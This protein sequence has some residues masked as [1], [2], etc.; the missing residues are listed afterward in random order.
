MTS[1]LL[2]VGEKGRK[3]AETLAP[4]AFHGANVP[5]PVLTVPGDDDLRKHALAFRPSLV[6]DEGD[7]FDVRLLWTRWGTLLT[8]M[9]LAAYTAPN[10]F[11]EG[12]AIVNQEL[13]PP[14]AFYPDMPGEVIL[15]HQVSPET[16]DLTLACDR[17]AFAG[18][19]AGRPLCR[20]PGR[21][22]HPARCDP[23]RHARRDTLPPQP[24][25]PGRGC[26]PV[27]CRGG[28]HRHQRDHPRPVGRG[29]PRRR[30]LPRRLLQ[31]VPPR[32]GGLAPLHRC[33]DAAQGARH[34]RGGAHPDHLRG[35]QQRGPWT[36]SPVVL[37]P[38]PCS[39]FPTHMEPVYIE[40]LALQ[41]PE[42]GTDE[43]V[44]RLGRIA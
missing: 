11:S 7:P 2:F 4:Q 14:M 29:R 16:G 34:H 31:G 5:T 35:G 19:G 3:A 30:Q 36:A 28:R 40:P 20:H 10:L 9:M 1:A 8:P 13:P 44:A 23:A 6:P 21:R 18:R 37:F 41:L 24:P 42:P 22:P 27:R 15:G 25:R 26:P 38:T 32:L 33:R 12:T 17:A 39:R 43:I